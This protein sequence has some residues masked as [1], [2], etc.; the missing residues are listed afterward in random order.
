MQWRSGRISRTARDAV[1]GGRTGQ[2]AFMDWARILAYLAE[3]TDQE[4]LARNEYLAAESR[5]MRRSCKLD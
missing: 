5:I 3:M 2:G 4:L 1:A